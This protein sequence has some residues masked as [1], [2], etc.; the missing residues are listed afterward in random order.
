MIRLIG[1]LT[2][3][4]FALMAVW[5]FGTGLATVISD[6]QLKEKTAEYEFHLKPRDAGLAS[7]GAFGKWDLA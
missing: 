6:G 1:I 3:L 5:G 2:G 7:D 4:F